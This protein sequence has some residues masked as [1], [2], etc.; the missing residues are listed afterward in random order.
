MT[1]KPMDKLILI[2]LMIPILV[3]TL[4]DNAYRIF[5]CP[6]AKNKTAWEEAS[7]RLKCD[8]DP[9]KNMLYHCLPSTYLNE[10]IEFCGKLSAVS[11]GSCPIYNYENGA[12]VATSKNCSNFTYG[13]PNLQSDHPFHTNTFYLYPACFKINKVARC[14]YAEPS[15]PKEEI[16][17]DPYT[18]ITAEMST[19]R[20]AVL[21]TST[22]T[23]EKDDPKSI[24]TT[25]ATTEKDDSKSTVIILIVVLV[26][27]VVLLAIIL[28]ITVLYY[29]KKSKRNGQLGPGD[30]EELKPLNSEE[31]SNDP[32][33]DGMNKNIIR[34]EDTAADSVIDS[35][36][37]A[38]DKSKIR[39]KDT[40][41]GQNVI[42]KT[43]GKNSTE[44][45]KFDLEKKPIDD[46]VVEKSIISEK[47]SLKEDGGVVV[48]NTVTVK[49]EAEKSEK[50]R[51]EI[52]EVKPRCREVAVHNA[53]Y[54]LLPN[55]EFYKLCKKIIKAGRIK[56]LKFFFKCENNSCNEMELVWE[57]DRKHNL[58]YNIW[59]LQALLY[60]CDDTND[61]VSDCAEFAKSTNACY[62]S[63][64][65]KENER[66][67]VY[68]HTNLK[69]TDEDLSEK[70][71]GIKKDIARYLR[72]EQE[73]VQLYGLKKGS[74]I[75]IFSLPKRVLETRSL[76]DPS[77]LE[78]MKKHKVFKLEPQDAV[79]IT[80]YQR[81][82]I[83]VHLVCKVSHSTNE[84]Q[85]CIH[86]IS[87][88]LRE[89]FKLSGFS[90]KVLEDLATVRHKRIHKP[91]HK[92][93]ITNELSRKEIQRR[94]IHEEMEPNAD[95]RSLKENFPEYYNTF[96][97]AVR[98]QDSRKGKSKMF[99]KCLDELE[100]K[101]SKEIQNLMFGKYAFGGESLNGRDLSNRKEKIK[102]IISSQRTTLID[103]IDS[104]FIDDTLKSQV[105]ARGRNKSFQDNKEMSRKDRVNAFLDFVLE[106]EDYLIPFDDVLNNNEDLLKTIQ[107]LLYE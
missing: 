16:R 83:L 15:C 32:D 10:T 26:L 69:T 73:D 70:M 5:S 57:W 41:A 43:E 38:T 59:L 42:D 80:G 87:K 67:I 36:D 6:V 61:L 2:F 101:A 19:T 98:Q 68:I 17:N 18:D 37:K 62:I 14:Y 58:Q 22:A 102:T 55:I 86:V 48:E 60:I 81:F 94:K 27:T 79:T 90:I 95:L 72:I 11:P 53:D 85:L 20:N 30:I 99:L 89:I 51:N 93:S 92:E 63:R 46:G 104:T 45:S 1:R 13:C 84:E 103:E 29:R 7:K 76:L 75:F 88:R 40:A 24:Y 91:K 64:D 4:P 33:Y 35:D 74:L 39:Q 71:E 65:F 25:T 49:H 97:L 31:K 28:V 77:L 50:L 106:N 34:L 96:E 66:D 105:T 3:G 100:E 9:R 56:D 8:E 54:D 47:M 23:K 12:T 107:S 82:N 21:Y 78:S 44:E 52:Q